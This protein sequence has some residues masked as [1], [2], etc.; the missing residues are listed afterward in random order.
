MLLWPR[1]IAA[2]RQLKTPP[3]QFSLFL[4]GIAYMRVVGRLHHYFYLIGLLELGICGRH[5]TSIGIKLF[6]ISLHLYYRHKDILI[7]C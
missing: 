4:S 5:N 3:A 6:L 7:D 2:S 1:I